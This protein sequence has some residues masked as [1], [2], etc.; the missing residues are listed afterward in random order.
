MSFIFHHV[1]C[2]CSVTPCLTSVVR[3]RN[4]QLSLCVPADHSTNT[5]YLT[6]L[7]FIV[8]LKL[9]IVLQAPLSLTLKGGW[10]SN[11][12]VT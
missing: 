2:I 12:H 11:Y 3:V 1:L 5:Y 10:R 7:L 8:R 9:S 6:K 4:C